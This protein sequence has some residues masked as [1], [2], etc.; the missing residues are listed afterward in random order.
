MCGGRSTLLLSRRR[1][2]QLGSAAV[3]MDAG[4]PVQAQRHALPSHLRRLYLRVLVHGL[5]LAVLKFQCR[6]HLEQQDLEL[7]PACRVVR[8]R[9]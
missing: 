9:G 7:S 5:A 6:V 4:V 8:S 1:L 3:S 2:A